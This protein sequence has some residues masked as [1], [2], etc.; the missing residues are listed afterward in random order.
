[1]AN[2]MTHSERRHRCV[3]LR[4]SAPVSLLHLQLTEAPAVEE[5]KKAGY[6]FQA[7]FKPFTKASEY[8]N[9]QTYSKGLLL[10]D[11]RGLFFFSFLI[12]FSL[13]MNMHTS[14]HRYG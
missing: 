5:K 4:Q 13:N 8:A 14:E 10:D 6:F 11:I 2:L 1:M 9:V 12:L 7:A 3:Q